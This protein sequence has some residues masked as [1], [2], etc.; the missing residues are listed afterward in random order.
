MMPKR[1]PSPKFR[2]RWAYRPSAATCFSVWVDVPPVHLR[3]RP[4]SRRTNC[5]HSKPG[6]RQQAESRKEPGNAAHAH[7]MPA[8]LP[9]LLARSFP[10]VSIR[11]LPSR[12]SFLIA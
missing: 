12:H 7:T 11:N 8:L 10:V 9:A 2:V 6:N 3:L 5:D 1:Q 4:R